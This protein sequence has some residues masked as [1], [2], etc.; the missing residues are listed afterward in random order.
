MCVVT[1]IYI[2]NNKYLY[3]YRELL[4]MLE[5][6]DEDLVLEYTAKIVES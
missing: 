2:I 5:N 6:Y 4:L 3:V 1:A